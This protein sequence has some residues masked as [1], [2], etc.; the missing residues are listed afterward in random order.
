MTSYNKRNVIQI[1]VSCTG[2]LL[3][4]TLN[5]MGTYFYMNDQK[6]TYASQDV[7]WGGKH[8]L[9]LLELQTRDLGA[10]NRES[11]V[12]SNLTL[13]EDSLENVFVGVEYKG[14]SSLR[15]P[16]KSYKLEFWENEDED[17]IER[18]VLG[19]SEHEDW[20]LRSMYND[21]SLVRDAFVLSIWKYMASDNGEWAPDF[22][23]VELT[24]NGQ[25]EGLYMLIEAIKRDKNRLPLEKS[26]ADKTPEKIGYLVERQN[27]DACFDVWEMDYPKCDDEEKFGNEK[28]D[29]IQKRL[30]NLTMVLKYGERSSISEIESLIDI[31]SFL[32]WIIIDEI[33]KD[34]DLR[35]ASDFFYIK[36]GDDSRVFAGPLWDFDNSIN[37]HL[38]LK[39]V[40]LE[41]C[42]Y[43]DG[44]TFQMDYED[45]LQW[46]PNLLRVPGMKGLFVK[47]WRE[48]RELQLS[49]HNVTSLIYHLRNISD[50]SARYNEQRWEMLG[51]CNLDHSFFK[52]KAPCLENS[53]G[54]AIERVIYWLTERMTWIDNNVDRID[55]SA[56][57]K[58]HKPV[59]QVSL[60]NLQ[61]PLSLWISSILVLASTIIFTIRFSPS[62][63]R[64]SENRY[65]RSPEFIN[66]RQIK[67]KL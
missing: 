45:S 7:T 25:Y 53:R 62:K 31:R 51:R 65:V 59:F 50:D 43:T 56:P 36:G 13:E 16:K 41:Q 1:I 11:K 64:P 47:R 54:E 33:I 35:A 52:I 49:T 60:Y 55:F 10:Y 66:Y 24:L 2:F 27:N 20:W 22:R 57:K 5:G 38:P 67:I 8:S 4:I 6:M 23:Y 29:Y 30:K 12:L 63:N 48:L 34:Y 26:K 42:R 58:N 9:P 61:V 19:M 18:S 21:V 46:W 17:D 44:W 39:S 3:G 40:G 15:Y 37:P 14:K 32:D 28:K